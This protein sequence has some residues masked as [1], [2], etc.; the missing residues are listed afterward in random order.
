MSHGRGDTVD[1]S[2]PAANEEK[3]FLAAGREAGV[4]SGEEKERAAAQGS[5][6]G[7]RAKAG[8]IIKKARER[9]GVRAFPNLAEIFEISPRCLKLTCAVEDLVLS[10]SASWLTLFA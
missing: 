9:A 1:Q 3:S 10:L 8:G 4:G 7:Q 6:G 2:D 5:R